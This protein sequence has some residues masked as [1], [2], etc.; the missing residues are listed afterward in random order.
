M[1][2]NLKINDESNDR[3][4]FTIIPNYILNHSTGNAQS[5]Y[6]Q[7]KRLAGEKGKAY[8]GYRYLEDKLSISHNTIKK[9]IKYLLE[10]GWIKDAGYVVVDTEGGPQK[11]RAFTI[12][13]LWQIN[14]DYYQRGV[15][16]DTPLAKG[17]S[18]RGVKIDTKE[19]PLKEDKYD[20]FAKAQSSPSKEDTEI[21]IPTEE[22]T[23][24]A[25]DEDGNPIQ[26]K[27]GKKPGAPKSPNIMAIQKKFADLAFKAGKIRPI[28]DMK[29]YKMIQFALNTG[30]LTEPQLLDLFDEW[31][32]MNKP[33]EE[34]IQIT[35]ALSSSQINSYK[36]RNL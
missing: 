16:I 11:V 25:I 32:S 35:R 13:D 4:Y 20:D 10:K 24:E 19:D 22:Y 29:G 17:G 36:A 6:L 9:E 26:G 1:E 30:G 3:G 8:P 23:T 14:S 21:H 12:V 28:I 31:F 5:L 34:I 7:L 15:K 18:T 33:D 2:D 27:W